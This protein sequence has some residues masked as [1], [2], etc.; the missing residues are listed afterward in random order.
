MAI[1][2]II[3]PMEKADISEIMKNQHVVQHHAKVNVSA[4]AHNAMENNHAHAAAIAAIATECLKV[5]VATK[6]I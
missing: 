2:P 3:T 4:I 6:K 1:I 5:I